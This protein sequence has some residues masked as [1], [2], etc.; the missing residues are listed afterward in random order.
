[1]ISVPFYIRHTLPEGARNF[2]A[3]LLY[4]PDS[5]FEVTLALSPPEMEGQ[6]VL[7][8]LDRSL[9][10]MAVRAKQSVGKGA[11]KM[12][13]CIAREALHVELTGV[14]V[15]GSEDYGTAL[16]HI[17]WRAAQQFLNKT[18]SVVPVGQEQKH[19]DWDAEIAKLL[20]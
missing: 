18:Y 15:E 3:A 12:H 13:T 20:P 5:P 19:C 6:P 4:T 14:D 16:F 7:W 10:R 1:M 8:K 11:V 9:L 2:P 17:P